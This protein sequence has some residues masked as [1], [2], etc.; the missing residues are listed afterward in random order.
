MS[1]FRVI[2]KQNVLDIVNLVV[3]FFVLVVLVGLIIPPNTNLSEVWGDEDGL[4]PN[5]YDDDLEK[6]QKARDSLTQIARA[7]VGLALL[8]LA[9]FVLN[10]LVPNQT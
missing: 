2:Q 9:S 3:Q 1:I 4:I 6:E 10:L 5:N 7:H 8:G